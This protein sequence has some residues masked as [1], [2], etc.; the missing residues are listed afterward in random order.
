MEPE[1]IEEG[2]IKAEEYVVVLRDETYIS[3]LSIGGLSWQYTSSSFATLSY[4]M[5]IY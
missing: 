4:G 3:T 5:T 1:F 2:D